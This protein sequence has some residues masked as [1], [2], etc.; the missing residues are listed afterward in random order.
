MNHVPYRG[1]APM[2]AELLGG[3]LPLGFDVLPDTVENIRAGRLRAY[4]ITAPGRLPMAPDLP[5]MAEVGFPQIRIDDWLGLSGP[6]GLP[7][8]VVERLRAECVAALAVPGMRRRLE[9][10]GIGG[11]LL[12]PEG[13]AAMLA[14]QVRDIGGVVAS[15]GIRQD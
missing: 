12:G 8:T 11:E 7:A 6:A 14:H 15:P 5:T 9:E 2:Q 3:S 13:F 4:A 1:S 10:R